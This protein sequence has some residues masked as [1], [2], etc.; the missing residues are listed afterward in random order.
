MNEKLKLVINYIM[1]YL[2]TYVKNRVTNYGFLMSAASFLLLVLQR[3]NVIVVPEV[4]WQWVQFILGM[5]VVAGLI[6]NPTTTTKGFL[7]DKTL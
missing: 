7:D 2:V 1:A 5:L 4:Y 6:N 3:F